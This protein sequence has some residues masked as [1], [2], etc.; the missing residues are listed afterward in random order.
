MQTRAALPADMESEVALN[1]ESERFLSPLTRAKLEAL[2]Q[3]AELHWVVGSER[4]IL[5]FLLAFREGT[6]YDSVNYRWFAERY[7]RFLYVDRV[8]VSRAAQGKGLGSVLYRAVFAHAR[9]T[10]VPF[11]TC[12]FDINPPNAIS[13]SFHARFG[14][15]EVGQQ[16][17]A[18]GRKSVS[19][20]LAPVQVQN[21]A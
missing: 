17:V 13:A 11:V 7:P 21:E 8:V 19:L 15:S 14:F 5:A 3:Q 10:S 12:E 1:L 16:L 20:Q 4:S 2:S 18:G 6:S 9:A